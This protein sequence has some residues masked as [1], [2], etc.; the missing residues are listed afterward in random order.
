MSAD[1]KK[2]LLPLPQKVK[3][4]SKGLLKRNT[5]GFQK[6]NSFEYRLQCLLFENDMNQL[7][8]I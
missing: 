2:Y 8:S 5:N 1:A 3:L 4:G 7:G 6:V